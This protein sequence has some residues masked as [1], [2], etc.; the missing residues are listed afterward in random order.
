VLNRELDQTAGIADMQL[1]HQA[2]AVLAR[3]SENKTVLNFDLACRVK[4]KAREI[5]N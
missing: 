3:R 5:T 2:A 1:L 4:A